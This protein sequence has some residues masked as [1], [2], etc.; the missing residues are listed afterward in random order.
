MEVFKGTYTL[1]FSDS[2]FH[3]REIWFH[4]NGVNNYF[5]I[6]CIFPTI[7][8]WRQTVFFH[9][10]F[11]T[12]IDRLGLKKILEIKLL[13]KSIVSKKGWKRN[14]GKPA[15]QLNKSFINQV[16]VCLYNF[17]LFWSFQM[18]EINKYTFFSL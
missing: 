11:E 2:V 3:Y 14:K 9:N 1:Q 7:S 4:V 12:K 10:F 15:S 13:D 18:V 5:I 6:F 17:Q 8:F 16:L